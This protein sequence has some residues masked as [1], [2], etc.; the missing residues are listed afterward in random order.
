MCARGRFTRPGRHFF[1]RKGVEKLGNASSAMPARLDATGPENT[2][3]EDKISA[4]GGGV[5][6]D[7]TKRANEANMRRSPTNQATIFPVD[8]QLSLG[9]SFSSVY[10]TRYRVYVSIP[11]PISVGIHRFLGARSVQSKRGGI[12]LSW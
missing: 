12:K 8:S 10:V 5:V 7:E 2:M 1:L 9:L 6:P 11:T 4:R 3:A